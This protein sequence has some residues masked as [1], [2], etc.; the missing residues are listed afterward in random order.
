MEARLNLES[1]KQGSKIDSYLSQY[2]PA[3]SEVKMPTP[4]TE[5]K[6]RIDKLSKDMSA[7]QKRVEQLEETNL[8]L[9]GDVLGKQIQLD[10]RP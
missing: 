6:E 10:G 1:E 2:K 4:H 5:R 9:Q 3:I 8:E 7:L